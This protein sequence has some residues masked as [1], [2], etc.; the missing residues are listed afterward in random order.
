LNTESTT[1]EV[2][3]GYAIG[4]RC[5]I[6]SID[7]LII[8]ISTDILRVGELECVGRIPK[9]ALSAARNAKIVMALCASVTCE[10]SDV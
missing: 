10:S 3:A 7:A 6:A 4:R 5:S 8:A 1:L 2:A 9:K